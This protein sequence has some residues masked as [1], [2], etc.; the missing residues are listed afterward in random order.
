VELFHLKVFF[1]DTLGNF[2]RSH[3][4]HDQVFNNGQQLGGLIV[5]QRDQVDQTDFSLIIKL[6]KQAVK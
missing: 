6:I 4:F 5:K 3:F 2:K 1:L